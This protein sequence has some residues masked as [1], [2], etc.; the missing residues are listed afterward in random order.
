MKELLIK[1]DENILADLRSNM[2]AKKITGNLFGIDNAVLVRIIKA[3]EEG[4][5]EITLKPKSKE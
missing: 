2:I 5:T 4:K 1:I 3:I